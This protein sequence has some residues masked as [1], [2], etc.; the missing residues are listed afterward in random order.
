[1][2]AHQYRP[3][4]ALKRLIMPIHGAE[5]VLASR[6]DQSEFAE[7]DEHLRGNASPAAVVGPG[8]PIEVG[9][10]LQNIRKI[11]VQNRHST[12][13]VGFGCKAPN[14][15]QEAIETEQILIAQLV[16]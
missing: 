10:H 12:E 7:N 4:A 16:E 3:Q 9:I 1:M 11:S 2:S 15:S 6:I 8:R 14:C 13:R 5:V